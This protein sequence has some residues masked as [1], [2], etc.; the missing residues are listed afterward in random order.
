MLLNVEQD[1]MSLRAS[2]RI[3]RRLATH[4]ALVD[5]HQL[6]LGARVSFYVGMLLACPV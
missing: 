5:R 1:G 3:R 4:P 6:Q 2:R